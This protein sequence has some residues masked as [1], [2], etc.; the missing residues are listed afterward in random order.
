M[1]KIRKNSNRRKV[2]SVFSRVKTIFALLGG[3]FVLFF[4]LFFLIFILLAFGID[5]DYE[6]KG[7]VALIKINGELVTEGSNSIFDGAGVVSSSEIVSYIREAKNDSKIKAVL[8]EINSPGGSAVASD[9][10]ASAIRDLNKPTI[11][12]IREVGASGAYWV[13]SST[14]YIFAN[15]ASVVGSIG[16]YAS[17]LDFSKIIDDFNIKYQRFVAGESKDFG[18]PYRRVTVEEAQRFQKQLN[19]LHETFI[20]VVAKGRKLDSSY[21]KKYADGFIMTGKEAVEKRFVDELGGRKEAVAYLEKKIGVKLDVVE[22]ARGATLLELLSSFST[23]FSKN[24][25]VGLGQVLFKEN[26][27]VK[28]V[29]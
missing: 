17:W 12:Y 6:H 13:A 1:V 18:S 5:S 20:E 28:I 21:V 26:K 8:L 22:Y 29:A 16:V 2:E 14:D 23:N 15:K 11:S 25:G 7:K 9:E 19:E 3:A 27:S 10:I 4:G 24:I